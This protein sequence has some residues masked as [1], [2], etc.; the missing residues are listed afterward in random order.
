M[1]RSMRFF[2]V[3]IGVVCCGA[4]IGQSGSTS[5]KPGT[6]GN[7]RIQGTLHIMLSGGSIEYLLVSHDYK[8]IGGRKCD[9]DICFSVIITPRTQLPSGWR[10]AVVHE[11][12]VMPEYYVY[13]EI[14]EG[15]SHLPSGY[16]SVCTVTGRLSKDKI[17][18]TSIQFK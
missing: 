5:V 8:G 9:D 4:I 17:N 12:D 6:I 15:I 13:D 2:I 1:H 3:L 7:S 11:P 16:D 14:K 10:K 18:A